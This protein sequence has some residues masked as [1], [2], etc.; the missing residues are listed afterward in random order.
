MGY[1]RYIK[2]GIDFSVSLLVIVLLSPIILL[3]ATGLALYFRD[4]PFFLQSR[5]GKNGTLFRIIKFRTMLPIQ[6]A[7]GRPRR[8]E[9]RIPPVGA[10][11]RTC[12]LDEI[13]QFFNVLKGNMSLIGPRPLLPK[14]LRL[15]T[16]FQARRHA[17]RPGITGW[18]QVNGRNAL[19]WEEKFELDVYYVDHLHWSLD[20]K[21][22][23]MTITRV[24][25]R[26]GINQ[27]G[28]LPMTP[29]KGTNTKN[30]KDYA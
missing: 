14:Y 2:R 18:A 15:Y 19:S 8:I 22:I 11:L 12:S 30:N 9:D 20:L 27:S 7:K 28:T 26:E 6:D 23:W 5:P 17:C 4:N 21:I 29:F 16:P 1:A 3:L 25:R 10:F 13:P 24:L